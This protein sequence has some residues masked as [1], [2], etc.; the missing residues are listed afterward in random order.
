MK[1]LYIPLT[2]ALCLLLASCE[3]GE[4][5]YSTKKKIVEVYS[6]TS[7]WFMSYN[8]ESGEWEKETYDDPRYRC[9]EWTWDHRRLE[10]IKYSEKNG[11]TSGTDR[12]TYSGGLVSEKANSSR[13]HRT[14]YTYNGKELTKI[15]WYVDHTLLATTDLKHTDG[16]ITEAYTEYY[17]TAKGAFKQE[18][19]PSEV[20]TFAPYTAYLSETAADRKASGPEEIF[21]EKV[22]I[23]WA[24]DDIIM[25]V[26]SYYGDDIKAEWSFSYDSKKNPLKNFWVKEQI[27]ATSIPLYGCPNNVTEYSMVSGGETVE[28]CSFS[29]TYDGDYPTKRVCE[30][31]TQDRPFGTGETITTEYIY[32]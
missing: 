3:K 15:Q 27:S 7:G 32:K 28:T 29:Y 22:V 8:T 10:S 1:T 24:N 20:L 14:V 31:T 5:V 19:L 13:S 6:Q 11:S 21:N 23:E 9:E 2:I 18:A 16:H 17:S 12:F 30:K 26:R 25:K 4:G